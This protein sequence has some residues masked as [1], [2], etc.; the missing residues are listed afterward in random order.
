MF[1][2]RGH[3]TKKHRKKNGTAHEHPYKQNRKRI[4]FKNIVKKSCF[5]LFKK[6]SI[7]MYIY[8][9]YSTNENN[10]C[11]QEDARRF[12]DLFASPETSVRICFER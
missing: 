7:Y 9:K 11:L 3:Y 5:S 8:N 6:L 10:M 1:R 12:T 4:A 2:K